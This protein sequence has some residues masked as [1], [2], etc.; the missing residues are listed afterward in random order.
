MTQYVGVD[1]TDDFTF[2]VRIFN[3]DS[4]LVSQMSYIGSNEK[5]FTITLPVGTYTIDVTSINEYGTSKRTSVDFEIDQL[6][7]PSTSPN[8]TSKEG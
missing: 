3:E 5:E 2:N 1:S 4:E 7:T 8:I 6:I